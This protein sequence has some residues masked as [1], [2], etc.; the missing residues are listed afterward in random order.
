MPGLDLS[1]A[2]AQILAFRDAR[3]W[4]QFHFPKELAAAVGIEAAELQ[5]IFLWRDRETPSVVHEDPA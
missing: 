3:D 1:K 4:Q 2:M 5:E